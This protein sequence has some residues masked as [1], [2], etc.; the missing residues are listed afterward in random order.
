M[1]FS[2]SHSAKRLFDLP[3]TDFPVEVRF[4]APIGSCG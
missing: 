1:Y 2:P 3:G 4:H